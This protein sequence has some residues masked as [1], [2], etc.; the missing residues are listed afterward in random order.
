MVHVGSHIDM[1]QTLR[2]IRSKLYKLPVNLLVLN[3]GTDTVVK[4]L[5]RE[6]RCGLTSVGRGF[7]V[8]S[9]MDLKQLPLNPNGGDA[10]AVS[11]FGMDVSTLSPSVAVGF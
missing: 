6:Y 5:R 1:R 10:V 9:R 11:S 8:S 4:K 3:R 2:H 7:K